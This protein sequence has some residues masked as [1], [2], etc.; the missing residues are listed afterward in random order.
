MLL[1]LDLSRTLHKFSGELTRKKQEIKQMITAHI[2]WKYWRVV[3][4]VFDYH[5]EGRADASVGDAG[6]SNS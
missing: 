4:D 5:H 3:V 1:V 2:L 6:L